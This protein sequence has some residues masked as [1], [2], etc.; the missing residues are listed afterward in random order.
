MKTT[1]KIM[2]ISA[3]KRTSINIINMTTAKKK[4]SKSTINLKNEDLKNDEDLK[5]GGNPRKED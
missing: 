2:I 1:S 4:C 3:M 5:N